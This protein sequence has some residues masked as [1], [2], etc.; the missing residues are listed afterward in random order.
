M[1]YKYLYT[2]IYIYLLYI[3][4]YIL[5]YI[6]H[7]PYLTHLYTN[8]ASYGPK[9]GINAVGHPTTMNGIPYN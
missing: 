1:K 8:L 2:Y 3:Y 9:R 4:I 7:K 6:C 5:I